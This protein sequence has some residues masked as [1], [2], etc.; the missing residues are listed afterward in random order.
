MLSERKDLCTFICQFCSHGFINNTYCSSFC[1]SPPPA[2][3]SADSACM[4]VEEREWLTMSSFEIKDAH[5]EQQKKNER[6]PV[7]THSYTRKYSQ[8]GKNKRNKSGQVIIIFY[9]FR[10]AFF[11][12]IFY[13][14][15]C[16]C[17]VLLHIVVRVKKTRS[18]L[19]NVLE[20]NTR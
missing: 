7:S 9:I 15:L 16:F 18:L 11:K 2:H 8:H 12:R 3:S 4:H 17:F 14:F 20:W 1:L 13:Q 19:R 6:E 10:S 5:K